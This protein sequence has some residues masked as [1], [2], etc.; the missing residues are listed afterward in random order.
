MENGRVPAWAFL[1]FVAG[2]YRFSMTRSTWM[3]LA[4]LVA[5][6]SVSF[7]QDMDASSEMALQQTQQLLENPNVRNEAIRKSDSAQAA[8]AKLREVAGSEA[9]TQEMYML[10]SQI[11]AN[12][13]KDSGGDPAKMQ[14]MVQRAMSNP[15]AFANSLTPEQ[16][17]QL[18][19][20][21]AK[22]PA[23]MQAGGKSQR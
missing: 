23:A 13:A 17:A 16:R 10:A 22:S 15:E 19:D 6:P 2:R 20:L 5:S 18:K 21:A 9:N 11:F 14:E 12:M 7:A 1:R 8:D 4:A 3:L